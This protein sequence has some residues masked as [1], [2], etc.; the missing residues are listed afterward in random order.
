[1][2][3]VGLGDVVGELEAVPDG[4]A[5]E[6][7]LEVG[8]LDGLV[9]GLAEGEVDGVAWPPR[10]P[11]SSSITARIACSK[12][13]SCAWMSAR[14]TSPMFSPY[15]TTSCQMRSIRAVAS[16]LSGPSRVTKSWTASA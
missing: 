4:S 15:A 8:L 11:C 10:G 14:G 16:A 6:E 7:V 1:M 3:G 12:A 13:V 9:V 2:V 5:E